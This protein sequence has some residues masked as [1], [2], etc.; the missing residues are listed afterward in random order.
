MYAVHGESRSVLKF[1]VKRNIWN[2]LESRLPEGLIFQAEQQGYLINSP[3][4]F[5]EGS[6]GKILLVGGLVEHEMECIG[7][8]WELDRG[9][10]I[11]K[12][13]SRAPLQ[14]WKR[15]LEDAKEY[16]K[17]VLMPVRYAGDGELIVVMACGSQR[18]ITFNLR[19]EQWTWLDLPSTANCDLTLCFQP[20]TDVSFIEP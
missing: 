4:K 16:R 14:M 7:V 17:C 20:P 9:R 18:A 15:M 12:E 3:P 1:D 5:V 11:W 8:V 2:H 13:I 6:K 19:E 10:K